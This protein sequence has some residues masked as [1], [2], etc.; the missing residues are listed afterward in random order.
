MKLTVG[1][2]PPVVYWR[3]RAAL[4]AAL[5]VGVT[6]LAYSCSKPQSSNAAKSTT[7][8]AR[9]SPSTRA[10]L[11]TPS[12]GDTPAPADAT[13]VIGPPPG[14][15]SGPCADTDMSVVPVPAK[16]SIVHGESLQI[17]FKIKN[18]STRT[19]S[20]DVGS[21]P[22]ELYLQLGTT[23]IWS[24]DTCDPAKTAGTDV[25]VFGPGVE[26]EFPLVWNGK[27][28]AGGCQ[29]VMSPGD[30]QLMGRLATKL[31]DPVPLKIT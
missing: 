13:A 1:P 18:I 24:S 29:Q 22:Q 2:L 4:L 31:S 12:V 27:S 23:K 25:R 10:T 28:I 20:R 21:G 7:P 15:S 30:Y 6:A 26:T 3:R 8:A 9:R 19:C 17:I 14:A 16:P 5:L 11:L